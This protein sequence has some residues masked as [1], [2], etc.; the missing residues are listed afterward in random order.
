M[1]FLKFLSTET[2]ENLDEGVAPNK[3]KNTVSGLEV[4]KGTTTMLQGKG[5]VVHVCEYDKGEYECIVLKGEKLI[6]IY[7]T[8]EEQELLDFIKDTFK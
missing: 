4:T 5:K 6:D 8:D 7:Y 1:S 2:V 3:F